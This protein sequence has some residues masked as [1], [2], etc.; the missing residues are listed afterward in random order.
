MVTVA[1]ILQNRGLSRLIRFVS[2][3]TAHLCKSFVNRLYL[4]FY[5]YIEIFDVIIFFVFTEFMGG[6]NETGIGERGS[7]RPRLP[8]SLLAIRFW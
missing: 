7:T 6:T 8:A 3:F 5:A 2:R 1:S 4:V